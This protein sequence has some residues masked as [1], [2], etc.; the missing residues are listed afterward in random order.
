M[1]KKKKSNLKEE[2]EKVIRNEKQIITLSEL[3]QILPRNINKDTLKTIVYLQKSGKIE[4]TPNGMVWI[5]ASK[6][7]LAAILNKGRTW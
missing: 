7:D 1:V 2:I 5:F 3:E 4:F 6:K